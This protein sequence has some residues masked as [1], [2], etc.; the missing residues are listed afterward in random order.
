MKHRS[1]RSSAILILLALVLAFSA[2]GK[3]KAP[4]DPPA[5]SSAPAQTQEVLQSPDAD[6]YALGPD[7]YYEDEFIT[8]SWYPTLSLNRVVMNYAE[9]V[10]T[11]PEGVKLFFS[12]TADDAS[13]FGEELAG[14]DFDSY[15]KLLF[16]QNSYYYLKEFGYVTVDSHTA[17]RAVYEYAPK[18]EPDRKVYVLQYAYNV[19]GWIMNAA[20]SSLA[21]LPAECEDTLKTVRFKPGY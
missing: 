1:Y 2:C 8:A 10:G 20:Y 17:L 11:T 21:P 14:H 4:S 12:Y 13:S 5:A 18:E 16:S 19:N 9:Y 3:A 7:G 6:A 15:Q